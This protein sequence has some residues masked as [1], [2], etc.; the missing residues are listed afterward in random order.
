MRRTLVAAG[1]AAASVLLVGVVSGSAAGTST[2]NEKTIKVVQTIASIHLP[3]G[4]L[5]P[6]GTV[7]LTTNETSGGKQVGTS[8]VACV[9]IKG[10]TAECQATTFTSQGQIAGL[11]PFDIS[12]PFGTVAIVGGTGAYKTARGFITRKKLSATTTEVTYHIFS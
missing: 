11:G 2:S 9:V 4:G 3:S 7:V 1:V 12:K 8:Q 6:G 10:T 5:A